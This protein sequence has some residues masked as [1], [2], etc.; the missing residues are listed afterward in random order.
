[1]AKKPD[2]TELQKQSRER[3]PKLRPF[4]PRN[5]VK[6]EP[7]VKPIQKPPTLKTKSRIPPYEFYVHPENKI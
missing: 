3:H 1:M 2:L 4:K 6:K 7:A 5:R